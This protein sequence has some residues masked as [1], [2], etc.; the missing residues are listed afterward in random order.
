MVEHENAT[1]RAKTDKRNPVSQ[2]FAALFLGTVIS[3]SGNCDIL[4]FFMEAD[5]HGDLLQSA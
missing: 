5:H 3:D 4:C 1:G 2:A